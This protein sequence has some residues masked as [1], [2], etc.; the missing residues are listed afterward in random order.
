MSVKGEIK[1]GA[2]FVKEEFNEHG[3]AP[4]SKASAGRSRS[5]QRRSSRRRQGAKD[6]QARYRPSGKLGMMS[7]AS[8]RPRRA[9]FC[10]ASEGGSRSRFSRG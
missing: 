1:E 6:H 8:T 7:C 4:Q 9:G 5:A 3:K 10:G 2:G